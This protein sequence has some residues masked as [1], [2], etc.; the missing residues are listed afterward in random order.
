MGLAREFTEMNAHN[1]ALRS[2]ARYF[3][4]QNITGEFGRLIRA[5]E[6]AGSMTAEMLEQRRR[7]T[8]ELMQR[9]LNDYG[10]GVLLRVTRNL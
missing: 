4:Y 7:L 9:I 5:H 10:Q 6:R 2:V 8:D 1:Y 3:G